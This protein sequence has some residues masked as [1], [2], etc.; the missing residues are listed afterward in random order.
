MLK[1][2]QVI[3]L[4]L[5]TLGFSKK[6]NNIKEFYKFN[7]IIRLLKKLILLKKERFL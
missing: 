4:R 5:E 7:D 6:F 3:N 2:L 1:K